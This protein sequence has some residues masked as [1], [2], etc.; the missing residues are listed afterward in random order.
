MT[1][2]RG[3]SGSS[4]ETI[5]TGRNL[6][7]NPRSAIQ[8]SPGSGFIN[9]VQDFLLH[10]ARPGDVDDS[11]VSQLDNLDDLGT[12]LVRCLLAPLLQFFVQPLSQDVHK[13]HAI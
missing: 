1:K 8:T 3:G 6:A 7:A 4:R 13:T 5:T 11:L 10:F 2:A 9:Q 12:N